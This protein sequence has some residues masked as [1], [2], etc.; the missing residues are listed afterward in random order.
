MQ[1]GMPFQIGGGHGQ[2]SITEFVNYMDGPTFLERELMGFGMDGHQQVRGHDCTSRSVSIFLRVS[3]ISKNTC[4]FLN[5]G[6][7]VEC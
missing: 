2:G 4:F 3:H 1:V 5:L 7:R 6:I